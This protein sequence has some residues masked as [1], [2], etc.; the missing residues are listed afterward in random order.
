LFSA[1]LED[2]GKSI[3][4]LN[5]SSLLAHLTARIS[6]AAPAPAPAIRTTPFT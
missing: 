4:I 3:R 5:P 1:V 2:G 6:A